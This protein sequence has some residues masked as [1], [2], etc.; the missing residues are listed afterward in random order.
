MDKNSN[1][2][3]VAIALAAVLAGV[4]LSG[5]AQFG[6][7]TSLT[8]SLSSLGGSGGSGGGDL[9]GQN[10]ALVRGYVAANKDVLTANMQ[11]E[12]A[13]GLKDQAAASKATIDALSEGATKG[14]LQDM[15]KA[16]ST[17]TDAVS[18]EMA[19]GPKLDAASKAKFQAGMVTLIKGVIKYKALYP[20]AQRFMTVVKSPAALMVGTK[21]QS[22]IYVATQLPGG[23][24]SLATS[25]GNA[26][27]F[28]RS[29]DIPVPDDATSAM[30]AL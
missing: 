9:G 7:L 28:A 19:K 15:D 2:K 17:S 11:M 3:V 24:S 18:A 13:L 14:N 20:T 6:S 26:T 5:M 12:E 25:V 30:A 27:A 1:K 21:L 16:V 29:S 10:D 8:S 22:G 4:P 23:A